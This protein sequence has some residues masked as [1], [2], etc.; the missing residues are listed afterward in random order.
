MEDFHRHVPSE[1][2]SAPVA[3]LPTLNAEQYQQLLTLLSKQ[4]AAQRMEHVLW[5]V[6][7]S[8]FLVLLRVGIGLYR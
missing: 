3:S 2:H 1:R 7:P 4:Q 6:N 5:Q 8:V